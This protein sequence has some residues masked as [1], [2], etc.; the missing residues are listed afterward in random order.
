MKSFVLS[1]FYFAA[2]VPRLNHFVLQYFKNSKREP[3]QL[4]SYKGGT[5]HH[6]TVLTLDVDMKTRNH[7]SG[8]FLWI[9]NGLKTICPSPFFIRDEASCGLEVNL[10]N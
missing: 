8:H 2:E 3:F 10:K 6:K 9:Y 7:T 4:Q 5:L 1:R